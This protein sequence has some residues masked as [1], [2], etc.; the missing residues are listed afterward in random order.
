MTE[1]ASSHMEVVTTIAQHTA[2]GASSAA[3]ATGD[4]ACLAEEMQHS[5]GRFKLRD[6]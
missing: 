6:A 5:L 4:P 3:E 1:E 2:S